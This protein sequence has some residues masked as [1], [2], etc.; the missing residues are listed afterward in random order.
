VQAI[1]VYCGGRI[2]DKQGMRALSVRQPLRQAPFD[3]LRAGTAGRTR[4]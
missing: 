2:L 3:E 1:G 4:S